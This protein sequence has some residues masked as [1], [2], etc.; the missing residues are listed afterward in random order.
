MSLA[1]TEAN[2]FDGAIVFTSTLRR[3]REE[4]GDRITEW[5]KAHPDLAV[6]DTVV[7]LSSSRRFHCQ[8][9]VVFWRLR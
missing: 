4:L 5:L 2:A 7:A 6:V 8:S 1:R 9:I 3:G